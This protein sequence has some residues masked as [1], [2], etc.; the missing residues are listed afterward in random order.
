MSNMYRTSLRSKT[1][2]DTVFVL[3]LCLEILIVCLGPKMFSKDLERS[4]CFK[5]NKEMLFEDIDYRLSI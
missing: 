1:F 2:S 4:P 3:E 5:I